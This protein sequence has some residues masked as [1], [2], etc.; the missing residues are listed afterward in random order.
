V[1]AVVVEDS[2]HFAIDPVR[3]WLLNANTD[4]F[5]EAIGQGTYRSVEEVQADGT[6][7]RRCTGDKFGPFIQAWTEAAPEIVFARY[8]RQFRRIDRGL[9]DHAD[10]VVTFT[11]EDGGTRLSVRAEMSATKPLGAIAIALGIVRRILRAIVDKHFQSVELGL[12]QD[13]VSMGLS[14][15][16]L[17]EFGFHAPALSEQAERRLAQA[18]VALAERSGMP[19][20]GERL[21]D[22]LVRAPNAL[23]HRI[24]PLE[25]ARAWNADPQAVVDL[26]LCASAVGL[27]S[28]RWEVLCPGCRSSKDGAD[29][30]SGLPDRL[31]C[32]SCNIDYGRDFSRNVE[33]L[34][35]PAPWLRPLNDEAACM[36]GPSSVPHIVVQREVDA[37][38]SL[39]LDPP[40]A[41]GGYRLRT[42]QRPAQLELDWSGD[43]G[44]P[45]VVAGADS[46]DAGAAGTEGRLVLENT[47]DQRLTII[48]EELTW[49]REALR[50]DQVIASAAFRRYCPEQLLRPGDDVEIGHIA[51]MFTDMK[52]STSRYEAIGDA[53]AYKLVRDH[54]AYLEGL[55][56]AH[57]GV[58]VKT[59]GDAIM[60]AFNDGQDALACALA[61]QAGLA[62]FNRGRD[63]GGVILK[64][65][66]HQGS[67]IAVTADGHL[68]YFGSVVNTAA[69]LQD[70]SLGG[71]VVLSG[72]LHD[73]VD[74]DAVRD[75]GAVYDLDRERA[76]IRGIEEP[77]DYW[78][79]RLTDA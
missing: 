55:V 21:I 23:L 57:H 32:G 50:G 6:V 19:E 5:S 28:L 65:G 26:M 67:C 79:L 9:F 60:A 30:L 63:D 36:M 69:R 16:R 53:A 10:Y 51:L 75:D 46:L 4:V 48:V 35:T 15:D 31:H 52:S 11:P 14:L 47:S 29:N 77:V 33:L 74:L 70:E 22:F 61:A 38:Q 62:G 24:R 66:V 45:V 64:I 41:P 1:T 37:G 39:V 3:M 76:A 56:E 44:F 73:G 49:R 2:R 68:D 42:E 12:D 18:R 59:M 17:E 72:P 43:G 13:D 27:L 8:N 71:D 25:M 78:R 7:L 54:F 40:L 20:L 58:I 34:F